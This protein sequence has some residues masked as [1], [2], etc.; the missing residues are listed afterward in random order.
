MRKFEN[1]LIRSET[2]KSA[3]QSLQLVTAMWNEV[4][5]LGVLPPSD[6]WEGS[7]HLSLFPE[8]EETRIK[9]KG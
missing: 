4:V 2:M 5:V 6:P 9:V 8:M 3:E 1:D 7:L